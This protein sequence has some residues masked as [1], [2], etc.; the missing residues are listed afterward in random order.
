M[1]L[2]KIHLIIR[3]AGIESRRNV[4]QM[5]RDGRVTVNGQVVTDPAVTADPEED[6]IKV[7]GKL[8]PRADAAFLYYLLNKPR[9]VVSTLTDPEGRLC[10]GDLI[11]PLKRR[12]FPVGRLDFD[13]EGLMLLTNDGNLAHKMGH[14]SGRVPRTYMVK[15]KG[16]PE[17]KELAIIR[18][19]MSIGDG[20]RVG[21]VTWAVIKRQKTSTWI[22]VVLYEGKRNEIKRIF[23]RIRHPV[24]KIRRI[25]FGPLTLGPLPVG[26]WRPLTKVE[27]AKLRSLISGET[28]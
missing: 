26:T 8:I 28:R 22:K 4:E 5:I 12:L 9:H 10:V 21:D 11:R 2:R 7:D 20:E 18:K 25:A 19:G 3:D 15:V 23:S 14:P 13:A 6:H 27:T 24:R 16:A 1:A 17:D